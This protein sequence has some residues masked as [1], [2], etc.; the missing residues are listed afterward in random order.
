MTEPG[1]DDRERER[2]VE[3][4]RALAVAYGRDGNL[5]FRAGALRLYLETMQ[6]VLPQ[7]DRKV[8]LD[9]NLTGLLPLLS[10]DKE[11]KP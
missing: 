5:E 8:I 4:N 7:V 2:I 1:F 10:L 6:E 3:L 11:V 9:E